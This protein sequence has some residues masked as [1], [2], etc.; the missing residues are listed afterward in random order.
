[1]D[2]ASS[3]P[4]PLGYQ[5]I[6]TTAERTGDFSA[7]PQTHLR[8]HER[9]RNRARTPFPNNTIPT[10]RISKVSQ[11]FQSYLPPPT[12]GNI[13]NNYLATLPNTVNNDSTTDKVDYNLSDKH[14]IFALFSH[15]QVRLPHRRQPDADHHV[16]PAHTLYGRKRRH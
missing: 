3:R 10:S 4:P 9:H 2:T 11:S 13:T 12:N 6:P 1:M 16:D 14:R 8:S 7:F 15:G 5:S